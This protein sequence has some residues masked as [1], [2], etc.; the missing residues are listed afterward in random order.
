MQ[1]YINIKTKKNKASLP[2][3]MTGCLRKA[4]SLGKLSTL[5]KLIEAVPVKVGRLQEELNSVEHNNT[6][7]CQSR[8]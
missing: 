6:V 7:K 2:L 5:Q 3:F 8:I 1:K 4:W